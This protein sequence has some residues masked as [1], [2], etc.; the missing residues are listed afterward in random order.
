MLR[1]QGATSAPAPCPSR[2]ARAAHRLE[3]KLQARVT[4]LKA[5]APGRAIE[6]WCDDEA[7]LGVQPIVRTVWALRGQR[8]LAT[9]HPRYAWL[10]VYGFVRPAPGQTYWLILPT[11]QAQAM[12]VALAEFARDVG[13]G[14]EQQSVLV[15]DQAGWHPRHDVGGRQGWRC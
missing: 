14:A 1:L 2:P 7:R 15:L 8:P 5:A 13:A 4:E 9:N 11:V 12:T 3:N 6:L 10:V